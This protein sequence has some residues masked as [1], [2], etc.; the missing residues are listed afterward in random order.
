M[1][2]I[3]SSLWAVSF[4]STLLHVVSSRDVGK[5][6][7]LCIQSE[8]LCVSEALRGWCSLSYGPSTPLLQIPLNSGT[9]FTGLTLR[10]R[11]VIIDVHTALLTQITRFVFNKTCDFK[12]IFE[13][14]RLCWLSSQS[15]TQRY[16]SYVCHD[17][18]MK[19]CCVIKFIV[20]GV[21][22]KRQWTLG[23]KEGAFTRHLNVK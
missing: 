17:K 21:P 22:L 12:C 10:G 5:K 20:K 16:T 3:F 4:Y 13:H 23:W 1:S 9:L 2:Y 8:A 18:P 6:G 15:Y 19:G 7:A 14:T 11:R